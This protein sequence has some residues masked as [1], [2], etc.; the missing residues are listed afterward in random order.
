MSIT[1]SLLPNSSAHIRGLSIFIHFTEPGNWVS[2]LSMILFL[3]LTVS[4][5][6]SSVTEH[7][8]S[9]LPQ[10]SQVSL[11]FSYIWFLPL[12]QELVLILHVPVSLFPNRMSDYSNYSWYFCSKIILRDNIFTVLFLA[13]TL[14]E[15]RVIWILFVQKIFELLFFPAAIVTVY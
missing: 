4:E 7:W 14:C 2:I 5:S 10:R 9:V 15:R 11:I 12:F 6:F 3:V 8:V 13:Q 1:S